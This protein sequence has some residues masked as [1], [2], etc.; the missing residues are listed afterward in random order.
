MGQ[1]A[2]SARHSITSSA[3]VSST[4]GTVIPNAVVVF[5]L[6]AKN[7]SSETRPAGRQ[8]P[9]VQNSV[10]EVGRS[11]VA[12]TQ[13]DAVADKSPGNDMFAIPVD[14][15]QSLLQ[16][17][18]GDLLTV[19]QQHRG[20]QVDCRTS[21]AQFV[22]VGHCA[23]KKIGNIWSVQHQQMMGQTGHTCSMGV[24]AFFSSRKSGSS[25][26]Y[27]LSTPVSAPRLCYSLKISRC[28]SRRPQPWTELHPECSCS[29]Q[30]IVFW[31]GVS[32]NFPIVASH[33][34]P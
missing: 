15:R 29:W 27:R 4:G 1:S 30:S 14:R 10:H 9:S 28:L 33:C 26:P 22:G 18:C 21:D 20:L 11:V 32:L 17:R 34:A 5:K 12:P 2:T 31:S 24:I 6:T 3:V 7:I 16:R 23:A 8:E 13:I 19:C 25:F